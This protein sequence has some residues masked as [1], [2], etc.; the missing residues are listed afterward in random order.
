MGAIPTDLGNNRPVAEMAS[1]Y[2]TFNA[3]LDDMREN[4]GAALLRIPKADGG[5]RRAPY[6]IERHR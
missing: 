6:K 1:E 3:P 2:V 4:D 5:W